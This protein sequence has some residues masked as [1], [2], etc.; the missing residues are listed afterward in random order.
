[1]GGLF[2][3]DTPQIP[4]EDPEVKAAREREQARAEAARDTAIQDKLGTETQF[5]SQGLGIASLRGA[6]T[7]RRGRTSLLGAG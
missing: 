7:G 2:K 4:Q 6:L 5:R 1:M 3:P